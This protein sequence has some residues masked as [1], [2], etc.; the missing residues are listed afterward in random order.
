MRMEYIRLN[1]ANIYA[2][3]MIEK[4]FHG[5][6]CKK[7]NTSTLNRPQ[8]GQDISFRDGLVP[9]WSRAFQI[10][11]ETRRRFVIGGAPCSWLHGCTKGG[12]I[13]RS[14]KI[15]GII[16][17]HRGLPGLHLLR[18]RRRSRRFLLLRAPHNF[19]QR[20]RRRRRRHRLHDRILRGQICPLVM[21]P[22]YEQHIRPCESHFKP[23]LAQL[24][25]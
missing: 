22:R 10:L 2:H 4:W 11:Y 19:R 23:R 9:T 12:M 24:P 16:E 6:I 3:A 15:H 8:I 5:F 18:G 13:R 21:P 7:V 1:T 25:H 20:R 14:N 17:G